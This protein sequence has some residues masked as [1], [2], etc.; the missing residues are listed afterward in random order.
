MIMSDRNHFGYMKSISSS[1]IQ[2][3][4]SKNDILMSAVGEK[5]VRVNHLHCPCLPVYE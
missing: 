5:G 1:I 4:S 2:C 3:D